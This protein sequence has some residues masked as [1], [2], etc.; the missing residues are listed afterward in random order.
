MAERTRFGPAG[1]PPMFRLMGADLPDVPKLLREEGLDAL[2]YEAVRWGPKPQIS[3]EL[4][5]KLGVAA[6]ANDVQL[7]L[8]GSYFINL[9]GKQDVVEASKRR[10]IA[11]ATAADWMGAYV[12]L[13]HTGFY[14]RFEKDFA[15]KT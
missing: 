3:K 8:H 14:G 2:E 10:L 6:K 9:S 1:V 15:F 11:S 12:M 4:A 5:E 7:S 13:F